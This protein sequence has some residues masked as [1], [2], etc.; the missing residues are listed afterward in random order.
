[1]IMF[2]AHFEI[3]HRLV[4]RRIQRMCGGMRVF[5][6]FRKRLAHIRAA[7]KFRQTVRRAVV[8]CQV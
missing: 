7:L 4:K 2:P 5:L 3:C 6:R 8:Y 1:M